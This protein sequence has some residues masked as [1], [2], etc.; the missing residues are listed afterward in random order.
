MP[1]RSDLPKP[2]DRVR[3]AIPLE[4]ESRA[5]ATPRFGTVVKRD[6]KGRSLSLLVRWD[7]MPPRRLRTETWLP[8]AGWHWQKRHLTVVDVTDGT[9][10]AAGRRGP[11]RSQEVAADGG[12]MGMFRPQE[13]AAAAPAADLGD[14]E[15]WIDEAWLD[16]ALAALNRGASIPPP[17][18]APARSA[19]PAATRQA[20]PAPPQPAP[21]ATPA[22]KLFT[23]PSPVAPA[24]VPVQA[25]PAPEPVSVAAAVVAAAPA[26]A[27]APVALAPAPAPAPV[28]Y[29]PAEVAGPVDDGGDWLS[30]TDLLPQRR[31][32][33]RLR[34]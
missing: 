8:D 2:G 33:L 20:A 7:G 25:A 4:T 30:D 16:Q 28:V 6:D 10:P 3:L 17:A 13:A 29:A 14:I 19:A 22:S 12:S 26:P 34:R 11:A 32:G 27:P 24:P 1:L 18:A 9:Q 23:A 15:R 31:R 5:A 21:R